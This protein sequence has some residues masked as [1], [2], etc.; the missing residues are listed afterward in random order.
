MD[1][2]NNGSLFRM[3]CFTGKEIQTKD[4]LFEKTEIVAKVKNIVEQKIGHLS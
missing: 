1:N 3:T 2:E 4:S